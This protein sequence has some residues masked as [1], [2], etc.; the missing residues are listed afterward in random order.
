[1]ALTIPQDLNIKTTGKIANKV[2]YQVDGEKRVRAYVIPVQPGTGPQRQ[3]WAQ[4]RRLINQWQALLPA[5]Q[6]VWNNLGDI[7]HMSGFNKYMSKN[8]KDVA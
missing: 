4:F 8:L 7:F 6:E 3:W 1:V 2:Y 5:Q